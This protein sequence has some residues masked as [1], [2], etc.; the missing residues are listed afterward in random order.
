MGEFEPRQNVEPIDV[1]GIDTEFQKSLLNETD[2]DVIDNLIE[3]KAQQIL[4]ELHE[5]NEIGENQ[6][7][8]I[9]NQYIPL[10]FHGDNLNPENIPN[11][12]EV[13]YSQIIN[14]ES[15][16]SEDDAPNTVRHTLNRINQVLPKINENIHILDVSESLL[17]NPKVLAYKNRLL[18]Y[19][20]ELLL[21][22]EQLEYKLENHLFL[23]DTLIQNALDQYRLYKAKLERLPTDSEERPD[24]ENILSIYESHIKEQYKQSPEKYGLGKSK[25]FDIDI[26]KL[27]EQFMEASPTRD[28]SYRQRNITET[29]QS[30]LT[31]LRQTPGVVGV[32]PIPEGT[33]G[34]KSADIIAITLK[35]PDNISPDEI[36]NGLK[37][38][39]SQIQRSA[40]LIDFNS[41][42]SDNID[43]YTAKDEISLAE[44]QQNSTRDLSS[45][46]QL[47]LIKIAKRSTDFKYD[48][49]YS[50]ETQATA[51]FSRDWDNPNNISVLTD[52]YYTN[53]DGKSTKSELNRALLQLSIQDILGIP[54]A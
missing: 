49:N 2:P 23:Q 39:Y 12:S 18:D 22:K 45:L 36:N 32:I 24:I 14:H 41:L 13:V 27:I 44:H 46:F 20:R 42:D 10:E 4:V 5:G 50:P 26:N 7:D 1:D 43:L 8:A 29:R 28:E 19:Q 52:S 47:H 31:E 11:I 16:S 51:K 33:A 37:L 54:L 48:T 25:A 40:N 21:L 34:S 35:S 9:L 3:T 15:L 53:L 30:I 17:R 38:L 6:V